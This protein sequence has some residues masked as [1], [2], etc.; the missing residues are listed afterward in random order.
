MEINRGNKGIIFGNGI[1][2]GHKYLNNA[3]GVAS[4]KEKPGKRWCPLKVRVKI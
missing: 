3:L 1:I 4:V 2:N